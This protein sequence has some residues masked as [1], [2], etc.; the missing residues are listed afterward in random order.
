MD[1]A[2]AVLAA[3]AAN[4]LNG[5][6]VWLLVVSGPGFTKTETVSMRA[7][8]GAFITSTISSEGSLLSGTSK[9]EATKDATGGLLKKLGDNGVLVLKD[10]TTIPSMNRGARAPQLAALREIH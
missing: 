5:D 6:P 4:Q 8:A 1:A 9:K 3:A 10:F 7:G 2:H